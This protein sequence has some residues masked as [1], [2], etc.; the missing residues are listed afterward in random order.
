VLTVI[1]FDETKRTATNFKDV[2]KNND[3]N[4]LSKF[5]WLSSSAL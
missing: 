5:Y 3:S 2:K 1:F 4:R